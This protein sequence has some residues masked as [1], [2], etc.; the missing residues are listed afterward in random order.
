MANKNTK[1]DPEPL[2]SKIS[3][4][5]NALLA[6]NDASIDCMIAY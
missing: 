5:L 6:I 3:R 4:R 2:R 1:P